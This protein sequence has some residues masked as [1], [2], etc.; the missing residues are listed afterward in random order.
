MSGLSKFVT[1]AVVAAA[2]VV[3]LRYT[4]N[5]VYSPN[6]PEKPAYQV[7]GAESWTGDQLA[8]AQRGWPIAGLSSRDRATLRGYMQHF[9]KGETKV[10]AADSS[11]TKTSEEPA[12]VMTLPQLL[13]KADADAGKKVAKKCAACHTF[14]EGGKS[15][16]GPNLWGAVGGKQAMVDG[17]SYSAAMKGL[18]GSWSFE[19]LD[20]FLTKPKAF[21]KGTKMTF[22]G[23]KKP[24]DRANLLAY[25]RAMSSSPVALPAAE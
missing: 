15:G 12:I 7:E 17:F 6:Y 13:A 21:L 24:A 16:V 1:L 10:A 8:A 3:A 5:A 23:V 4:A 2:A 9:P 18:G 14:D 25:M 11:E 22:A 20:A 19:D